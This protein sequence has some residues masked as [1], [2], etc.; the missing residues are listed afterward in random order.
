M[1]AAASTVE[2]EVSAAGDT[3]SASKTLGGK[4]SVCYAKNRRNYGYPQTM[5]IRHFAFVTQY[6]YAYHL[7][8]LEYLLVTPKSSL[9]TPGL[10]V[11]RSP[12]ESG[13]GT[14]D[15]GGVSPGPQTP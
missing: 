13:V 6:N 3:V 15:C 2:K 8:Q 7:S 1:Q 5:G 9:L 10:G 14:A 12:P 11:P 4:A